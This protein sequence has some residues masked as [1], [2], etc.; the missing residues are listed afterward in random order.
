MQER[1]EKLV[2]LERITGY[3]AQNIHA[4]QGNKPG[5]KAA[6]KFRLLN[7]KPEEKEVPTL[8]QAMRSFPVDSTHGLIARADVLQR[9][10]ELKR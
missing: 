2:P 3:L 6:A 5:V 7:E 10:D 4:A 8:R 1:E 9:A